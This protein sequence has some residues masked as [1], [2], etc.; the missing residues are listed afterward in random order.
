MQPPLTSS[1]PPGGDQ[2]PATEQE[3]PLRTDVPA[4]VPRYVSSKRLRRVAATSTRYLSTV[5]RQGRINCQP[6]WSKRTGPGWNPYNCE[7]TTKSRD[8]GVP[9]RCVRDL[10]PWGAPRGV[11]AV[12]G[13]PRRWGWPLM[14]SRIRPTILGRPSRAQRKLVGVDV[15]KGELASPVCGFASTRS[16]T[17]DHRR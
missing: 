14:G 11:T 15:G 5:R 9:N 1:R 10:G 17:P 3:A 13:L 7:R 12:D 4:R 6:R 16:E 2:W 8:R